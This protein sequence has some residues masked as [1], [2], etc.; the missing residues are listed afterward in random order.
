[1]ATLLDSMR[2]YLVAQGVGRMPRVAG[3][4][5]PIWL[6]PAGGTPAPGDKSGVE[7]GEPVVLGLIQTI[8]VPPAPEDVEWREDI[9]D[10]WIRSRTW[11]QTVSAW[12][13]MRPLLIGSFA[14]QRMNWTMGD[15]TVMRSRAWN[16]LALLDSEPGPPS[17]FTSRASVL[18]QT[19]SAAHV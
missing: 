5:P 7:V 2:D 15:F 19:Y 6:Q 8:E 12:A 3:A 4:L 1:M 13:T 14:N 17:V 18:L 11:P 10:I 9:V 16:G